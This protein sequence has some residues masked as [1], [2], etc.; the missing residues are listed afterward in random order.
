MNLMVGLE[1]P[2]HETFYSVPTFN[3]R[4]E[5][6]FSAHRSFIGFLAAIDGHGAKFWHFIE[7]N[8]IWSFDASLRCDVGIPYFQ[9]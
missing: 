7:P 5:K 4:S 3:E 1:L 9:K 8:I 6:H 2:D